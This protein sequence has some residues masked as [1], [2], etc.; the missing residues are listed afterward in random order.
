MKKSFELLFI[1][2]I[3][4]S[5]ICLGV[6]LWAIFFSQVDGII[7]IVFGILFGIELYYTTTIK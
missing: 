4:A 2:C 6:G 7:L 1:F 3:F 5:S